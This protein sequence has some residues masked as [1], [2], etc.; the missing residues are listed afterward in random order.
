MNTA[1]GGGPECHPCV[2]AAPD[3]AYRE[4]MV[5]SHQATL[6]LLQQAAFAV[7]A[8]QLQQHIQ[9]AQ[10]KIQEHLQRARQLQGRVQ[11]E[12]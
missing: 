11:S 3:R 12:S 1:R 10:P 8:P 2:R 9:E 4:A 7:Q 6:D 5:Q